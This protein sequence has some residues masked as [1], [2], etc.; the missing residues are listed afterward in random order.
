[1]AKLLYVL[2]N[3]NNTDPLLWEELDDID[4]KALTESLRNPPALRNPNYK[5]PFFCFE[6]EREENALGL[7]IPKH[8][9]HHPPRG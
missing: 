2:L 1:M 7:L 9:D 8:W 5:S 3:Y 6:Y 4:F